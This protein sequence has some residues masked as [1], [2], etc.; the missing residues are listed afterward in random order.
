[1]RLKTEQSLV[2]LLRRALPHQT[3]APP[4]LPNLA[5]ITANG[6]RHVTLGIRAS[7]SECRTVVL[8]KTVESPLDGREIKPVNPKGNQS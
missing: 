4:H 6:S 7:M 2:S 1:M 5:L 8:E 3:R